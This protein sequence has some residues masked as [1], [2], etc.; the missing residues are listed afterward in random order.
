MP[1]PLVAPQT[2]TR[3]L[4][5]AEDASKLLPEGLALRIEPDA[6]ANRLHDVIVEAISADRRTE[7][8][9]PVNEAGRAWWLA[10]ARKAR[11]LM[12]MLCIPDQSADL[13]VF[14]PSLADVAGLHVLSKAA[15]APM[16]PGHLPHG[17]RGAHAF[18]R[19]DH[20]GNPEVAAR[21]A[22][23]T[24]LLELTPQSLGLLA[25][26]A[27][28]GARKAPRGK[29]GAPSGAFAENLFANLARLHEE[30]FGVPAQPRD[31]IGKRRGV[32]V[33]WAREIV[34]LAAERLPDCTPV[35]EL[36]ARVAEL[37]KVEALADSTLANLLQN[38]IGHWRKYRK[39]VALLNN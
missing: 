16:H 10:V 3:W 7:M 20:G 14:P 29:G 34:R 17:A 8:G 36:Q 23:Q 30:A 11:E 19:P 38:G 18:N 39:A 37:R 4:F 25:F 5:D 26:L 21:F 28:E 15:I 22:V 2:W 27:D 9:L 1:K 33:P 12:E 24:L 6:Y 13:D 32:S 35:S 31:K